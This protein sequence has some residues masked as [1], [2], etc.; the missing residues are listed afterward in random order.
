MKCFLP[1]ITALLLVQAGCGASAEMTDSARMAENGGTGGARPQSSSGDGNGYAGADAGS[2]GDTKPWVAEQELEVAL[3]VPQSGENFVFVVSTGLDAIVRIDALTLA[4]DLVEVG[5]NPTVMRT[6]PGTGAMVVI[7]SGT[8]DF[9]L[10]RNAD[11]PDQKP[12]TTTVDSP[13]PVN[14][15]EL[16]PDGK[17]AVAWFDANADHADGAEGDLQE[18]LVLDLEEGKEAAYPVAVGF[19]TLAVSF[20]NQGASRAFVVSETGISIIEL[21]SVKGPRFVPALP[22]TPDP[23][24]PYLDREVLV[25]P[26]GTKAVVRRGGIKELRVIDLSN[27]DAE[28]L[29][30]SGAPTDA[31]LTVDAKEVILAIRESAE[32]VRVPLDDLQSATTIDL[33]GTP[34][35]LVSLTPDGKRAVLYSTVEGAE[36][37]AV[38]ELDTEEIEVFATKKGIASTALAPDGR[39]VVIVHTKVDGNPDPADL[40]A[41][42]D[43]SY[44]YSVLDIE[45]RFV[46]LQLTDNPPGEIAMTPDG[47]RAYVLVADATGGLGHVVNDVDLRKMLVQSLPLG[48][49]PRHAVYVPA[50]DR[51]AVSQDHPVGRI[52][53]IDTQT[54]KTETVTGFELNGMIE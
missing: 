47:A 44:G 54:G 35:G 36:W 33:S 25:T 52:T 38:L 53:F 7:N 41:F 50:A 40:E 51:M 48:S 30:L 49:P 12:T 37:V 3:Q 34:A 20:A 28:T 42:V 46:K 15:L 39:S 8:Q 23:F 21:A 13:A 22:V 45:A 14:R 43:R 18:V 29:E 17:H 1:C 19:R 6:L 5:A 4:V 26:D 9:T 27:G 10:V 11:D 32:L 24:E 16:S 2:A 31:D